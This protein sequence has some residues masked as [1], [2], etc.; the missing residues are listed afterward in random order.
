MGKRIMIEQRRKPFDVERMVWEGISAHSFFSIAEA[1]L[2]I[3]R[4]VVGV[5][6]TTVPSSATTDAALTSILIMA[7]PIG[8]NFIVSGA[9]RAIHQSKAKDMC[10]MEG[11][12]GWG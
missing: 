5:A 11:E 3:Q 8:P 12:K 4:G 6:V 10:G 2:L 1:A 7:S 9:E